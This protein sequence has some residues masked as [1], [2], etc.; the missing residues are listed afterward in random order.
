MSLQNPG[1][2]RFFLLLLPLWLLACHRDVGSEADG[3]ANAVGSPARSGNPGKH[4]DFPVADNVLLITI[5]TL[6]YDSLGF[7]GNEQVT[8]PNLDRLAKSGWVFDRAYAHNVVTLPSHANILTGQLP[9]EH[10]VRS[11]IGFSLPAT[12]PTAATL[13]A[14]HG[15]AT[16]AFVAAYPLD[17]IFGLA[18][19]FAVYDD[20]YPMGSEDLGQNAER[21]G[22]QVVSR[23]Q[24]WWQSHS[25]QRRF[26]WVHLYDPHAPYSPHTQ[27]T[28]PYL[29][30]VSAIDR[31]L[32]PLLAP[33]L[34]NEASSTLVIF[35]AD[36]GEALGE[37]GEL[38]H[39]VFAYEGTLHVPLVIWA[40][41][42]KPERRN[43][44][45][46]HV[47]LLP[48]LLDAVGVAPPREIPGRS[49]LR[50]I[51]NEQPVYFESLTPALD[52]GWAPL[53][54]V[55][56][57]NY[58]FIDLPLPELYDLA[59]DPEEKRNL[60]ESDRRTTQKLMKELPQASRWPPNRAPDARADTDA[61]RSLGY[62]GGS[63]PAK[64]TYTAVDDPKNL[65]HLDRKMHQVTKLYRMGQLAEAERTTHEILDER[66]DMPPAYYY[67]S[68][69]LIADE[70]VIEA[71][72][73]MEQARRRGSA[74]PALLRQLG[75]SLSEIERFDDAISLL[76]SLAQ[77]GDPLNLN[78][79]GEV[80]SEAGDQPGAEAALQAVVS[81]DPNNATAHQNLALVALRRKDW[82]EA[83]VESRKALDLNDRLS[84]AW[85]YFGAASYQLG[86]HR[87]ALAAWEQAVQ[88]D[89][90]NFDALFNIIL[91]AERLDESERLEEALKRF[92]ASA[93]PSRYARDIETARL[94]LKE[95]SH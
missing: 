31:Y 55:I 54:G 68:L 46:S 60:V 23:A 89:P 88:R 72:E 26:L 28:D 10:G 27:S 61:L 18:R 67:L 35:T 69:V 38:T 41:K 43:D 17:H 2:R 39:G 80:L 76:S 9:Y 56:V 19:G 24:E 5:D 58:K 30:E 37:H 42:L 22:D 85:S 34:E 33:L 32:E 82:A 45:V 52:R 87:E 25:D 51:E 63:A 65:V 64:L 7:N 13:L 16:G 4:T 66:D 47:D 84:L 15:F 6:R 40:S 78:A 91:V 29:E 62:L 79:L 94:R 8:S 77:D 86:Q 74:S 48:T 50:S 49:L 20:D 11:N 92:V 36:H 14:D 70:R 1:I 3:L 93:P 83:R 44:L 12:V 57:G 73:V 75:L 81:T 21:K 59:A 90:K 95:M 71:V 53:R